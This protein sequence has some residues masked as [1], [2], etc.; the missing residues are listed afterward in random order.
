MK[1]LLLPLLAGLVP[2]AL[3]PALSAHDGH[4]HNKVKFVVKGKYRY[5]YANG[6]PDHKTGK[7]PNVGNPNTISEQRY[8]FRMPLKPNQNRVPI[9]NHLSPFGIAVNGIP[10]D[11]A[12]AEFWRRDRR[13]GWQ[14]EA[15]SGKINLGV[16]SSNAHVQPGGAYHYHGLPTG[17]IRLKKKADAMTLVGYAA[18][19][20]PIYAQFG[21]DDPDDAASKLRKMK[22]SYRVKKGKRPNGPGGTYDGTFVEDYEYVADAGDLDECNGRVGVTPEYPDGTYHYYITDEFPF[23]PRHFRGTP[24]ESFQRKGPPPGRRGPPPRGRRPPFGPPPKGRPPQRR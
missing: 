14:Y 15:L 5:V 12:A 7:F 6:I 19:G 1:H 18:D 2:L 8:T 11:P 3:A 10:Y 17:L 9:A 24:D 23:I 21:H 16:D 4:A 20:F 22:S 13:S